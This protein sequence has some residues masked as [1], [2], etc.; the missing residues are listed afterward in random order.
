MSTKSDVFDRIIVETMTTR[1]EIHIMA[2]LVVH[3]QR[4]FPNVEAFKYVWKFVEPGLKDIVLLEAMNT[5]YLDIDKNDQLQ[6]KLNFRVKV[7]KIKNGNEYY[8]ISVDKVFSSRRSIKRFVEYIDYEK[9]IPAFQETIKLDI[10]KQLYRE[11][12]IIGYPW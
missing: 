2:R 7:R 3:A 11:K 4:V 1:S 12:V 10:M 9:V 8:T 5:I 6:H